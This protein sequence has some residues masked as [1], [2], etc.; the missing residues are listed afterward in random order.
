M[1]HVTLHLSC[2][3]MVFTLHLVSLAVTDLNEV[4]IVMSGFISSQV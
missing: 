2:L 1:F 4:H 3:A